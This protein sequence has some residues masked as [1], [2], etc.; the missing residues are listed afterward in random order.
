MAEIPK[1]RAL[2]TSGTEPSAQEPAEAS[3]EGSAAGGARSPRVCSRAAARPDEG[4]EG[5]EMLSQRRGAAEPGT[6]PRPPQRCPGREGSGSRPAAGRALPS[7][8]APYQP[9]LMLQGVSGAL[10]M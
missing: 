3:A 6:G 10:L 2:N 9:D 8:A 5:S 1:R 7:L 4:G